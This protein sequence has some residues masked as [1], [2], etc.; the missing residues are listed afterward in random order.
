[1][2]AF[3]CADC[4][5]LGDPDVLEMRGDLHEAW[6]AT[7]RQ[8][9]YAE[10]CE[11]CGSDN[12]DVAYVC[13]TCNERQQLPGFDCCAECELAHARKEG[14]SDLIATI[15]DIVMTQARR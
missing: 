12:I 6:G 3:I 13:R 9:A 14:D 2:P 7:F 15:R 8:P 10:V 11:E 4:G 5:H 1:M